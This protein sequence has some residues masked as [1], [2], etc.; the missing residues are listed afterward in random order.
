MSSLMLGEH[1]IENGKTKIPCHDKQV[2][3]DLLE[4]LRE[5]HDG[6]D[7]VKRSDPGSSAG[8]RVQGKL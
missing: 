8:E 1:E 7:S 3:K 4:L 2:N 5:T 6:L